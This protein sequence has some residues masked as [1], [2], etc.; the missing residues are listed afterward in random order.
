MDIEVCGYIVF[1]LLIAVLQ[2]S[3]KSISYTL[4]FNGGQILILRGELKK[5]LLYV[6]KK[7]LI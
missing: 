3:S 5:A 7:S 4:Y 2:P 1:V 6:D